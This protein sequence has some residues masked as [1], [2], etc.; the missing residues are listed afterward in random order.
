MPEPYPAGLDPAH[1]L[2]V[3]VRAT[4]GRRGLAVRRSDGIIVC[5]LRSRR[6]ARRASMAL[7]RVGYDV[8]GV[9]ADRGLDL[10]STGWNQAAL[11]SRLATMRTILHQL[12]DSPCV[13]AQSVIERFRGLP[14]E[15]RTPQQVWELL[16]QARI[17]LR[18]WVTARSGVHA[19]RD[20]AVRPA[21]VGI[22]LRLRAAGTLEQAID[23]QAERQLRVAGCALVLFRR[24][25]E[26]MSDD[27]AQD[28]AI[29]WAGI[30]F[31]LSGS[32]ARG[33]SHLMPRSVT[34]AQS[35]VK[36]DRGAAARA[37]GTEGAS[38]ALTPGP[39]DWPGLARRAAAEFPNAA[40]T[41]KRTADVVNLD[42]ARRSNRLPLAPRL[43]P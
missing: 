34:S 28:T 4:G 2:A 6:T 22:A 41:P 35:T 14:A 17:G 24:L 30:A 29:R 42:P 13:T 21:D 11:G 25:S 23:D 1:I 36:P 33:S 40:V 27:Q 15:Q 31:H 10:L 12:A 32:T 39:A 3:C 20:S 38:A 43:R 9:S 16:N 5:L 18:D 8:V 26:Q 37:P 7:R 19:L